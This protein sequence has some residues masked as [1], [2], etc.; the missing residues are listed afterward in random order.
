MY[1]MNRFFVPLH[2]V[3]IS[4]LIIIRYV[5]VPL[6]SH[7]RIDKIDDGTRELTLYV[8]TAKHCMH[9]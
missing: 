5:L 8:N 6:G 9:H 3:L 4:V 2:L 1:R 7:S